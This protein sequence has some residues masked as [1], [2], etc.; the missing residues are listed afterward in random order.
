VVVVLE[1]VELLEPPPPQAVSDAAASP[2]PA[3]SKRV[4]SAALPSAPQVASS[5]NA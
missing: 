2:K 1:L 5:A 4:A 3:I